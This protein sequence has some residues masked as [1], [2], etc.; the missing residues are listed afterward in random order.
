MLNKTDL[1]I[2]LVEIG[3]KMFRFME[4]LY[5]INRSITGEGVRKTLRLIQKKIDLKIFEISSDTQVFDWT[6]P[7][8]WNIQDAYIMN[9]ANKKILDYNE[10]N[11]HVLQYSTPIKQKI[12]LNELKKHI[13]TLPEQ[14][15]IIP[16]VTSFYS[17][18]WGFCMKHNEFL[19][20]DDEEYFVCIDSNHKKGH[21]TYGEYFIKGNVDEEILISTYVCHPSLCNDNLSGPI[22]T[23]FL[24]E[25]L[26]KFQLHYSVRFLF[27]PETIGAITWLSINEQN[28]KNIAHGLV[29]TCLGDSGISTYKK[30]RD[31]DNIIDKIVEE[32]LIESGEE[33]K[34]LDFW[35]SGSDERQFCSPGF[36]LPIG[37][38][39]RT[40]YDMFDE[41][42]TSADNLSFMRKDCLA[43][44]L[45]KYLLVIF[46]LE[47]KYEGFKQKR[48]I[49]ETKKSVKNDPVFVNLFPKCEPQ[50]GK[51][52][53]YEN[54]G[55]VKEQDTLKQKKAIQ[56]ILNLSDG[57]H[58]LHDVEKKS[59]LDYTL[60]TDVSNILI[61]KKL[62]SKME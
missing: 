28:V 26:S 35:P 48:K 59:G 10:S 25:F 47:E 53:V 13:F 32:V 19:K 34:I 29:A 21:L 46:K 5:P 33:Y 38:L 15:N 58:S 62:L 52:G 7:N 27:I 42:H 22:L 8:E 4:M 3:D 43:N 51:R 57:T 54:I 1:E 9:S 12:S 61:D 24:A 45:L 36:N 49:L 31:G 14:P 55:G 44:S 40:P 56:W 17:E 2:N 37:S 20:L 60:L 30:S 16:Y 50:L 11:L 39:M 41:Y 6:I 18:N 23:T